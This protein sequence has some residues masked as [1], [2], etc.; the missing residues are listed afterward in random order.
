MGSAPMAE[1]N[2]PQQATEEIP[3]QGKP[4][5]GIIL[6]KSDWIGTLL[7]LVPLAFALKTLVFDRND[8]IFWSM[9][10]PL[11]IITGAL[12]APPGR[13]LADTSIRSGTSYIL[14]SRRILI[15]A[16]SQ[17]ASCDLAA[18]PE[19]RLRERRHDGTGSI[20]CER[21]YAVFDGKLAGRSINGVDFGTEGS[22]RA[23]NGRSSLNASERSLSTPAPELRAIPG[24][25]AVYDRIVQARRSLARPAPFSDPISSRIEPEWYLPR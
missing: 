2:V 10:V 5:Q 20:S 14:T 15:G 1:F 7:L 21:P 23:R 17:A 9:I 25:Q 8:T 6:R 11:G 4:G 12:F 13:W 16:G 22:F 19:P 24:V 3:W 18:L